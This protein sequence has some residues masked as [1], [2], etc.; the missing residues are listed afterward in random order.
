[1]H[2]Y[3]QLKSDRRSPR[4]SL[5]DRDQILLF[6][7]YRF[8]ARDFSETAIPII[9]KFSDLIGIDLSLVGNIFVDDVVSCFE[10]SK[11]YCFFYSGKNSFT[12]QDMEL[13]FSG[14]VEKKL[15]QC[16]MVL[17]HFHLEKCRSSP[18]IEN[19]IKKA[20]CFSQFSWNISFLERILLKYLVQKRLMRSRA[21][22]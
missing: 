10:I 15:K 2:V 1:M 4:C 5:R 8:W 19:K 12:I 20:S 14:L 16:L 21:F 9:V 18:K 7:F 11:I 3:Q 13:K 6:H 22:I 17:N